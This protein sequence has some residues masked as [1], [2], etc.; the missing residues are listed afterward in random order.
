ME[1]LCEALLSYLNY[2]HLSPPNDNIIFMDSK[3]E[4]ESMPMHTAFLQDRIIGNLDLMHASH[5]G[6]LSVP[7]QGNAGQYYLQL[8]RIQC[9]D[10]AIIW[11]IWML[12]P[13]P[14]YY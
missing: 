1:S 4:Q 10:D 8:P 6:L 12:S 7:F 2:I 9:Q 3:S 14:R 5:Q 11:V 13:F